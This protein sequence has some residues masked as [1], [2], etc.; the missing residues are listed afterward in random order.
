MKIRFLLVTLIFILISPGK[1]QAQDDTL[2]YLIFP[3]P[4]YM[5]D[6]GQDEKLCGIDIDIVRQLA[7]YMKLTIK[8]TRCPWKRCLLMM[9]EGQA[10]IISS[11]YKKPE[12][13]IYMKYLDRPY[14]ETLPIA[15]YT[16]RVK[17]YQ[18]EKYEDLYKL[19]TI[20]MLR[21]ASYFERFDNDAK[22][23]KY[24]VSS[25]E[26]LIPMLMKDRFEIFAGYMNTVN[27]RIVSEGL[28]GKIEKSAYEYKERAEVYIAIS[29][30]S[31]FSERINEFNEVNAKLINEG[32]IP[33]IVNSYYEKYRVE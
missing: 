25:Q 9:E 15:F 12:R 7:Q 13:E 31:R 5:I 10:D 8:F 1:S 11:A 4:P 24:D 6:T 14:L 29:K 33:K 20:G 3:A 21:G 16:K 26:Q 2:N 22:L 28:E 17:G 19:K 30:K 32:I 23:S 27:Y 18:I